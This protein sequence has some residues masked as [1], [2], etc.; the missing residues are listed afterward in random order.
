MMTLMV[1]EIPGNSNRVGCIWALDL[2]HLQLFVCVCVRIWTSCDCGVR[3][4]HPRAGGV[5]KWP[6]AADARRRINCACVGFSHGGWQMRCARPVGRLLGWKALIT[7]NHSPN[8]ERSAAAQ[9]LASSF[10]HAHNHTDKE[11]FCRCTHTCA[12]LRFHASFISFE[13]LGKAPLS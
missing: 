1:R 5:R 6:C 3:W 4:R 9:F 10:A 12:T 13:T 7:L 11:K 2:S 8:P